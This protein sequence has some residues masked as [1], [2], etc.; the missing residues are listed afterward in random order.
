MAKIRHYLDIDVLTAARERIEHILD[1]HDTPVVCF[2]GGKD[3]LVVL[4]LMLEAVKAR[5]AER[6]HVIFRDEELIPQAVIDFVNEYRQRG[7]IDLVWF[8]VPLKSQKYVLGKSFDYVQW[9][10]A[11]EHIREKPPWAVTAADGEVFDQYSMDDKVA[12]MYPGMVALVNGIRADESLLRL[13]A[14]LNKLSD[15]YIN[16]SAT[17]KARLCK[18]IYDWSETDV[19]KYLHDHAIPYCTF[20]D[21]QMWAAEKLRV[22]TPLHA[23]SAKHFDQ[24]RKIDPE[25]YEGVVKLFPEMLV[26]ERYFREID[27][28]KVVDKY[29]KTFG[30]CLQYLNE[31][32]DPE[33]RP[34]ARIYFRWILGMIKKDPGCYTPVQTI[35]WLVCGAF[36]RMPMP[37]P[38]KERK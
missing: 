31:F 38:K 33:Q 12:Q 14:S 23:E 21:R 28:Q 16:K 13:R 27:R 30:T 34:Q 17:K 9:D 35:K 3:S 29:G 5:G 7:D 4:H 8:C 11:R 19:F 15:S 6:L 37:I 22:S 1:L 18:P 26:Q 2:S 24:W 32:V 36:K 25:F 10:P 20:Y